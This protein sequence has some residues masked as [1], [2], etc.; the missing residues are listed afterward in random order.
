[1]QNIQRKALQ[2][3]Y[4]NDRIFQTVNQARER[5]IDVKRVNFGFVII[6]LATE[7]IRNL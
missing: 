1:V 2:I 5:G 7:I 4:L 6:I 3:I